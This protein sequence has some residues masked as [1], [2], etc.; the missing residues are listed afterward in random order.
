MLY[1]CIPFTVDRE[2]EI[3]MLRNGQKEIERESNLSGDLYTMRTKLKMLQDQLDASEK[4]I[5]Q[6]RD[7][8]C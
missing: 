7:E 1:H 2:T 6:L 8:V 5:R 3:R 4:K